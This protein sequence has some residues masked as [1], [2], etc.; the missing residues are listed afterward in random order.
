MALHVT[1]IRVYILSF[2]PSSSLSKYQ[3]AA[4]VYIFSPLVYWV[5]KTPFPA[6]LLLY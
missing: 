1:A 2:L 5:V 4:I 6:L 3:R